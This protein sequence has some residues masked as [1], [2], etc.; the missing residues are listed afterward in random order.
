VHWSRGA[1]LLTSIRQP[2]SQ[3]TLGGAN[4]AVVGAAADVT[5]WSDDQNGVRANP[6]V[7]G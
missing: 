2:A 4:I 6:Q 5:V 7:R 1:V 3:V